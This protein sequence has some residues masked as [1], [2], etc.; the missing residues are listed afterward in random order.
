[1]KEKLGRVICAENQKVFILQ[2][3]GGKGIYK[4]NPETVNG[5]IFEAD[6]QAREYPARLNGE[7]VKFTTDGNYKVLTVSTLKF[8]NFVCEE[9]S[10]I[11]TTMV[12]NFCV[13]GNEKNS[14]YTHCEVCAIKKD[15]CQMCGKP[16]PQ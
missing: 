6:P 5:N 10:D 12:G 3:G 11:C 16:I 4:F 1:M 13:C 8:R 9:C 15:C 2:E 14:A 7:I